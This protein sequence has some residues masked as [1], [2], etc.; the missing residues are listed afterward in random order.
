MNVFITGGSR[1]IGRA[2]VLTFAR[3]GYGVAFT[4]AGNEAAA[5]ETARL[6][7]EANPEAAVRHY[8]LDVR[9]ADAVERVVEKAIEEFDTVEVVVNNAAVVRNNAAALMSTEEWDDVVAV[10]LSGPFYVIRSFLMHFI[11]NRMGRIINISSLAET[12]ASGQVNYAAAKAGLTGLTNTLAREYGSK[13]ITA[14]IVTVGF[15]ETDMTSEHMSQE[16]REV[17]MKYCPMKR[18]TKAEEVAATVHFLTTE[19]AGFING[20]NIRVAGGLSYVP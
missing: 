17:W 12:G 14:N 1:G 4:Y 6:A 15:V 13:N 18:L 2:L 8:R 16:L 9:D 3:E 10:N 5:L 11:A 7:N 19:A 20:E